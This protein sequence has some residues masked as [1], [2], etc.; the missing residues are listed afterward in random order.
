[1]AVGPAAADI[2]Y[3]GTIVAAKAAMLCTSPLLEG[4]MALWIGP[5]T[6]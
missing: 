1:M 3:G 6:V 2:T 4:A 5:A